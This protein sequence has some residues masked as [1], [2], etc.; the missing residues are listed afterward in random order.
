MKRLLVSIFIAILGLPIFAQTIS[1]NVPLFYGIK[2]RT[3]YEYLGADI[4]NNDTTFNYWVMNDKY[5]PAE[6]PIYVFH[7]LSAKKAKSILEKFLDFNRTLEEDMTYQD[8]KAKL[9]VTKK[10]YEYSK[11]TTLYISIDMEKVHAYKPQ[12]LRLLIKEIDDF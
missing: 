8:K 3:A 11:D 12:V 4:V 2:D 1:K 7:G 9:Y 10:V 6:D 5:F